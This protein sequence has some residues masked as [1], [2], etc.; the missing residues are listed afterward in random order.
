VVKRVDGDLLDRDAMGL[1]CRS[2]LPKIKERQV[3]VRR[4]LRVISAIILDGFGISSSANDH[5]LPTSRYASMCPPMTSISM[6]GSETDYVDLNSPNLEV[7]SLSASFME[8]TSIYHRSQLTP[9]PKVV[10]RHDELRTLG[11]R[12]IQPW[13]WIGRTLTMNGIPATQLP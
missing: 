11:S 7:R 5:D 9:A 13:E 1:K 10:P 12:L 3:A 8:F 2:V 4:D 6:K